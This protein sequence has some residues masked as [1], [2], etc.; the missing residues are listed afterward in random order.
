M[1][2]YYRIMAGRA[3]IHAQACF[4]GGFIG[5]NFDI[6][7]DLSDDLSGTLDSFTEKYSQVFLEAN[8]GGS[9][10]AAGLACG[11]TWTVSKVMLEGEVVLTH[12]GRGTYRVGRVVGPYAYERGAILPHRRPVHW[13][14]TSILRADISQR[15]RNA[16]G[17]PGTVSSLAQYGPEIEEHLGESPELPVE[18]AISSDFAFERQLKEFL[19]ANWARTE[20]GASL[21]IF[22]DEAT[23]QAVEYRAGNIGIIDI[24]AVSKD[25]KRLV[26]VE[27]KRGRASDEVVGQIL[28]YM[29]YAQSHLA[30][31]G[32][33][34]EGI[35]IGSGFDE[36][37][38]M[39]LV[40][41]PSIR[42]YTYE[43]QFSLSA[44]PR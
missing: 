36:K 43:V 17:V 2:N 26:V 19:V 22:E 41:V 4:D 34:V 13:S 27:L 37:L 16:L 8:P 11:A 5:T 15:L 28:R 10:I 44:A 12:D 18:K 33:S 9:R 1:T 30:I 35:I 38:R 39:A 23:G 3:S 31:N 7:Q 20:L 25:K 14:E 24:L 6:H 29:G 32:E 21:D 42:M 40:P